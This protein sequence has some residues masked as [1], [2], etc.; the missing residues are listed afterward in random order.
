MGN[1]DYRKDRLFTCGGSIL[2]KRPQ[3]ISAVWG[4]G[5]VGTLGGL[6]ARLFINYHK[7]FLLIS[8]NCYWFFLFWFFFAALQM[9]VFVFFAAL[10]IKYEIKW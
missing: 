10:Q 2:G 4:A 5:R 8:L 6:Y 3:P 9:V 1:N 7:Y